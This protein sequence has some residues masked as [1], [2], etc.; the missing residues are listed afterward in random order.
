MS[1]V[2]LIIKAVLLSP[3]EEQKCTL[4]LYALGIQEVLSIA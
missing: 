1:Q 4:T 2:I 3:I